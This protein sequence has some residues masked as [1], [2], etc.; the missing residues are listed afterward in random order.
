MNCGGLLELEYNKCLVLLSDPPKYFHSYRCDSC[1]YKKGVTSLDAQ[2]FL[3]EEEPKMETYA[4]KPTVEYCVH[5]HCQG[6]VLL[7]FAKGATRPEFIGSPSILI[8]DIDIY[9]GGKNPSHCVPTRKYAH[10]LVKKAMRYWGHLHWT[11]YDTPGGVRFIVD[12]LNEPFSTRE[13]ILQSTACDP[14]YRLICRRRGYYSARLMPKAGRSVKEPVATLWKKQEGNPPS[15]A[16][17][18]LVNLH[19]EHLWKHG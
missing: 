9:Q 15:L 12:T 17:L 3:P 11:V 10:K 13:L 19:Y 5:S 14:I 1:G 7:E 18:E 6:K 8:G 16:Y 4:A 2:P